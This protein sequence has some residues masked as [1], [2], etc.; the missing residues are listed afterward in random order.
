M[1]NPKRMSERE[2]NTKVRY[3]LSPGVDLPTSA[4]MERMFDYEDDKKEFIKRLERARQQPQS[5]QAT[6]ISN[7]MS[8]YTSRGM[9]RQGQGSTSN[10]AN[11]GGSKKRRGK[12]RKNKYRKSKKNKKTKSRKH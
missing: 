1:S 5:T 10:S 6:S 9:L 11:Y 4:E 12:S 3:Y 7:I 2:F 8:F